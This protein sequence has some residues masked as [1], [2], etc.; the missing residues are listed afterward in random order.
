[1][2]SQRKIHIGGA[3][4]GMHNVGDEAVLYCMIQE[5]SKRYQI[6]I[7]SYDSRWLLNYF[8]DI[9]INPI[10]ATYT[11][12]KLG[13][14]VFPRKHVI[15]NIRKIIDDRKIFDSTDGYICGGGTILSDC[16]WHSLKTV[17]NA[18]RLGKN[19][20]LWGVGMADNI[21]HD[22][23]LYI[24]EMLNKPYVTRIYTRDELVCN[25][26]IEL[27]VLSEKLSVSYDPAILLR[28]KKFNISDYLSD[29]EIK[30]FNNG[31]ENICISISG[32][33]DIAKKTPVGELC[34]FLRL[35][36]ENRKYNIFFVPTGCGNHCQDRQLLHEI[37][38]R[39]PSDRVVMVEKEFEPEYLVQFLKSFKFSVSSRL[40]L[41][42]FSA[43]AGIPSVGL[44]R[45]SK[46]SDF[47]RIFDFPVLQIRTLKGPDLM[48][49]VC[50]LEDQ[51]SNYKT[52]IMQ[53]V[54][55]MRAK[56]IAALEEVERLWPPLK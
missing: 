15:S 49:A 39:C 47:A 1:M 18:G 26:L 46:I 8:P 35:I 33:A 3:F 45:N 24:K 44:I 4:Y 36:L 11:K 31:F 20:I 53:K 13:I 17:E 42:I 43:C 37:K 55:Y 23:R 40:H 10:N 21:D 50:I 12:P 5:F 32:E 27:G 16:P 2:N 34:E 7:S 29:D 38:N 9:I 41:N 19:T 22:T 14:S 6:S 25:H 56:Q 28:G 30:I 54:E 51:Y 52:A 48:K